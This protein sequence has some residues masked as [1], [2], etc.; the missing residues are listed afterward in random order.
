MFA[1][2]RR[3]HQPLWSAWGVV[4]GFLAASGTDLLLTIKGYS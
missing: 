4:V 2:G 3:L 1:V